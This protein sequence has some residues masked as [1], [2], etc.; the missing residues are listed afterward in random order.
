MAATSEVRAVVRGAEADIAR[1]RAFKDFPQNASSCVEQ[2]KLDGTHAMAE[3]KRR[4]ARRVTA[5]QGCGPSE[6]LVKPLPDS[7]K[8]QEPKPNPGLKK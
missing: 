8:R 2:Q 6:Q 4:K 7:E 3:Y 5:W 1:C